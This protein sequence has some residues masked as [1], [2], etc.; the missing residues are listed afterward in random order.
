[1]KTHIQKLRGTLF[2]RDKKCQAPYDGQFYRGPVNDD[3]YIGPFERNCE[4]TGHIIDY[5]YKKLFNDANNQREV[6]YVGPFNQNNT[7]EGLLRNDTNYR[8]NCVP[9]FEYR[10]PLTQVNCFEKPFEM[11]FGTGTNW[12]YNGRGFDRKSL[13]NSEYKTPYNN[14]N[15]YKRH[16]SDELYSPGHIRDFNREMDFY[17]YYNTNFDSDL[18]NYPDEDFDGDVNMEICYDCKIQYVWWSLE[19]RKDTETE[20]VNLNNQEPCYNVP[21]FVNAGVSEQDY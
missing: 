14:E 8:G 12:K 18:E 20:N 9:E 2:K 19:Q 1:M 21:N 6:E 15:S 11:N 5:E 13:S 7:F 17:N 4:Y 10:G 16:F 3:F